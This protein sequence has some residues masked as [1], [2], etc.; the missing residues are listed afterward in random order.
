MS[1]KPNTLQVRPYDLPAVRRS[2]SGVALKAPTPI[3]QPY[4][5]AASQRFSKTT[6]VLRSKNSD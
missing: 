4:S 6:V 1:D 2:A 5:L 3:R